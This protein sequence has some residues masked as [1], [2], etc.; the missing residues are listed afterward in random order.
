MKKRYKLLISILFIIMLVAGVFI[1][2][3]DYAMQEK[4]VIIRTDQGDLAGFVALPQEKNEGVVIFVHGDGA[5]NATQD[6]GYKPLMERF[7]KQGYASVS[8]DKP[9]VG[10][11]TGNWL[12]QTMDERAQEVED[13]MEWAENQDDINTE[14]IILWGASQAGWVIPKVQQKREDV[15]ASILVGPAINWLRQGAYN[16]TEEM[17]SEGKTEDEIMQVLNN[18]KKESDLILAGATYEDYIEETADDSLS[19]E[20]YAFV[21]KNISADATEDIEKIESPVHIVL[22][23]N[24]LNV[25]SNE[26]E[27]TYKQL[28][29]KS[30]LTVRIISGVDH[31][32][33]N[34]A[35]HE[36]QILTYLSA[37]LAPKDTLVS[38]EYLDYCEELIRHM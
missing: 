36:S 19:E 7:A 5:Q 25:D 18:D 31:S 15:T 20:R 14:K 9:G 11:S 37:I 1:Y 6:G 16:T 33:L 21:Q 10:K 30:Q 35:L 17:K 24:D 27:K 2:E 13:V 8:W 38:E 34:P 22:A 29:P 3:N 32:M 23:E 4:D 26:T 28:L 12:D